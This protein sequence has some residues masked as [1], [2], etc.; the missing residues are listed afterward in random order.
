CSPPVFAASLA[1]LCGLTHSSADCREDR[2]TYIECDVQVVV[3]SYRQQGPMSYL[4]LC[5]DSGAQWHQGDT[6]P[7]QRHFAGLFVSPKVERDE[8]LI[9]NSSCNITM[10]TEAEM[11]CEGAN[12]PITAKITEIWK[13][14][15]QNTQPAL[16]F[17]GR[18]AEGSSWPDG[19]PPQD[20]ANVTVEDGRT[21][22]LGS[23]TA[24]LHLLHLRGGKLLFT[25]PGP[26]ELHAHYILISDGGELRVGSSE[27]PFR[28]RAHIYLHGSLHSP[29]LF[30]YGVKFLA[31]KNGT[32]SIHGEPG[33]MPKVA[34]THLKSS[35]LAN[36]TR[37]VLREPVDWQ[38]GDEI[39]VGRTGLGYAQQQ[40]ETAVIEFVNNTELYLRS[41]LRYS[42]DVGEERVNGQSLP[43]TAVVALISRRVV[44]QGNV[45]R[46]RIS[47][48]RECAKAGVTRGGSPCLY[49]RSEKQ[50]GSRD[51]GAVVIVEAFQGMTNQLQVEGVQFRHMGQPFRQHHSALMVAGNARMA[52]SYIRGCCILDSF[53]QGLHL[54]GISNLS[55]D[56][57]VFYNIAGHGLL[58][59]SGLEKGNRVR[60]NVMIGLSGTDGLSNIETLSPAGIYVRA[61]ANH[62]EGNTVCAAGYGYFFHLSPEGPSI[63]P[64]LSF[65]ENTAHSCSRHGLLVYPEYLPDSPNSPVQFNSFTVWSSQGGAQIFRS[66][67]LKLQNFRIYACTDF[68][69]DIVESL[70]NTSV[71]N[72]FLIGRIE[73]KDRT[74]MST[75]LKTPKRYQLFITNTTFRNFD[76]NTCTAIRTCSGCYQGQGGFTVRAE[77]LTFTNSPSQVSFP[78]PHSAILEDLDGSISGQEGSC[79]LPSTDIL[80]ASC[81]ASANFSQASGG[82]VCGKDL[83]FHRMSLHLKEAPDIP[84][85]L[86]VTDSRN[87]TTTVNYVPD[88]LSNLYGWMCLLL[89]KETYTLT[90][91]NPLV[92]KQL[93]YS[94]TFSSFTAGN[95]L[96]VE[97]K[98]L[99]AHPEVVVSCGKRTGQPLQSLPSY[100]HHRSCDWYFNSTLKKLTYLVTGAD[101]I[102]FV[103]KE[104]ERVPTLPTSA[105]SD[106]ILK[107]SHPETWKD[108]EKGWGGSN[109]SIPGPGEDVIILPNR[110]ILVDTTLPPLRGLYIL[111]TLEFPTN[112][113]NVLSAA[114][115]VVVGGTLKVGSF[116]HPLERDLKLLI[117]LRASE[118]IYCD[119]LEEINVHPGS[120]GIYGK[121]QIYSAYPEKSWT[122]LEANVAPGNERILVED[123]VDWSPGEDIVISSSSYEA[124]QAEVVTLKEVNGHSITLQERLLHRHIGQPHDTEDGRRI[125]LS[126]EVGL[127]TRNVQIK[128]DVPCAG[129]MLVGHFT[130]SAGREFGGIL[131]LLNVEFLNFGPPQLSAIEFRNITQQSSV[132]SSSIHGSCGGGIQ[133]V[134]SNRI[135][136]HDNLVFNTVGPGINLEGQNHSLIGNLVILSRQPEGLLNW[137]AGIKVNLV[138]GV[139]L[140]GNVVAG[141][142]RI[143][144]HIRGQECLSDVEYCSENVAH[145]NLHGIHLYRG[146]GFQICT[147]ITGF[148]SYKNYDYGM[149]F[150]LGSSV[151][152]DNVVMVDNTV[153]LMPV[154]HCLDAKQCHMGQRFLELRNSV[155][156][157]TSSTFDCIRDRIEPHAADLTSRDR[158]P[159]YPQRGRVGILWPKFTTVSSQRPDNP[160]HKIVHCPKVLGLMKLKDVTFTGFRKSCYSEDRDV[161]IMSDADHLGIMPLITAERSRML[162]VSEKDKFYF[163]TASVQTS[164]D[165]MFSEKSCKGSRKALFKDLDGGVLDLEPPV[166]VFPKS[167][168]EWTQFYLQSGIY[169][170]DSKCI[171]KPSVQGYFCKQTDHALVILE[172][173]DPSMDN[174]ELF[175]VV[176]VTGSFMDTFSD[177]ASHVSCHPAEHPSTLF[178][179]LP[180]TKLTTVC[181]PDLTPLT[182][183]LYLLS[184]QNSTRL[185]LAIFYNEPLSL[186]VFTQGKYVSPTPSSFSWN[187]EAGTNYF[188]FKDNLLYVLLH[189]KEP[190]E[191]VTGLSLHVAF[192]VADAIGEEGE[193]NIIRRLADF[194]QVGHDQ[195]RVVHRVLGG[196]SMLKVIS[197]NVSKKKFHCPNMTFCT[198]FHS[199][200]GSQKLGRGAVNTRVVQPSDAAGPSKVLIIEFGEPPGHQR[201]EFQRSLTINSLKNLA[202]T[203]INTHQTGDLQRGLG[204]R[205]D[206]L[207]VNQPDLLFPRVDNRSQHPGTCLYV[208]PY[209]ISVQVQPSDGEIGKQIPVQPQIIFLDKKGRRVDNLGPPSEPWVVSAHLKGSSE[210]VLKGLTEVQVIDGCASF[211]SL[212]VSSSGT[213]WNLVFTV[214]S[215]PGA[216]FTVISQPFTIFPVPVGEKA[217]LILVVLLSAVASAFVFTLVPCWFK[218]SKSKK[219]RTK[220]VDVPQ[221]GTKPPQKQA[222]PHEPHIQHCCN[223]GLNKSGVPVA[224]ETEEIGAVRHAIGQPKEISLQPC[225]AKS[226]RKMNTLQ[227]KTSNRDI[228]S[229][230]SKSDNH[231]QQCGGTSPE[232]CLELQQASVLGCS[233]QKDGPQASAGCKK[234]REDMDMM[235]KPQSDVRE[236]IPTGVAAE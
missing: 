145:S 63:M 167:E 226:V 134:M 209:N 100:G 91:D 203:I 46:E 48:L 162:H 160:W 142:E 183:R 14:W 113:S 223:Q 206:T 225:E 34:F 3:G 132:V 207:M 61:P 210:A 219:M 179:I 68:G 73:Q 217:S 169:R 75:G 185:P 230:G 158:P 231:Q 105:P 84:Y 65:S 149:M 189:E 45:T 170:D 79:L 184:G 151:I 6:G 195:V 139:S 95:Y 7:S 155:I 200:S 126:A 15:G 186:H 177:M 118:G 109:C 205:V 92:S 17:C 112:S 58:L 188:S 8:V 110:T 10:E 190:V 128:S 39:I 24:A 192:T 80:A 38:P 42:H 72:S 28:H 74:C 130:D 67:N 220:Q 33:W 123:E 50:L 140:Y 98:D 153:G 26:V 224:G 62:I 232:D 138:I 116:H 121:V 194:L 150:H 60:N 21:L 1:I 13:N 66:S 4:Y 129:K 54:T 69:I 76:M 218:K 107:W 36:H 82:S 148:L 146:D 193:A 171:F 202:R 70:G 78:F 87:K 221:T 181:F 175:P 106:A 83:V 234:E 174:Q 101:L 211:S 99:P 5:G 197:D 41:P 32:L 102:Q 144:F 228:F 199:R 222:Q 163:H 81:T 161:C 172:N 204:L 168:F 124:H 131:Q 53:G 51:L 96:L 12:Q 137:V 19:R 57:N 152:I 89:D 22:L 165:I 208:R 119:H 20:G 29:P 229:S 125:P 215:P 11:E 182:F 85:N 114:C 93:Q 180:T 159:Y 43:L 47:H 201:N 136:L 147:R 23:A 59:G 115:I 157:A 227:R 212:A 27:A 117:L 173:L 55:V 64:L 2:S 71:A 156:V 213:N 154:I 216:K 198:S 97:H 108:V 187:E 214:T 120:I 143:G 77:H 25:G 9:Y 16:Q 122:H 56:S 31:V 30:P 141:S 235:C 18:W 164:E 88:T 90:F 94:V 233:A 49:K 176:A 86:T 37:L 103:L 236:Q 135:W 40:E 35:A 52:D 44:V 178:S 191:V 196:E 133:A 127:L 104:K 166:S 111:G